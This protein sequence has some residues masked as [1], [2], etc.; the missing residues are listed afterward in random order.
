MRKENELLSKLIRMEAMQ[1]EREA[2]ELRSARMAAIRASRV[3]GRQVNS[4]VSIERFS[5]P[6]P[7]GSGDLL[8]DASI[9]LSKGRRYG[10]IIPGMESPYLFLLSV[11]LTCIM[12]HYVMCYFNKRE[13][14]VSF[15]VF[16]L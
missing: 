10:D 16:L 15:V 14:L 5:L 9:T 1:R 8:T 3:T 6:H 13:L 11:S 12:L 7:S 2:E 4:G